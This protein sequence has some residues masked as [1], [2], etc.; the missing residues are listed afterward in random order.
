VDTNLD[1]TVAQAVFTT[2]V[3][4]RALHDD[5]PWTLSWGPFEVPVT[6]ELDGLGVTF[7][8][9]FPEFCHLE[10]P[11]PVALLKSGGEA[12]AAKTIEYP[13]DGAFTVEWTLRARVVEVPSQ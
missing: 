11:Y 7:R 9:D 13:G 2:K 8:A 3:L 12:V 10:P 1:L 5:G 4:E 6:R